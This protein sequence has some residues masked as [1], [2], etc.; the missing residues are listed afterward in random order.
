LEIPSPNRI[1]VLG[2]G[3][4]GTS[5]LRAARARIPGIA[6]S[7]WSRSPSSR[8]AVTDV[9]DAFG[10]PAEALVGADCVI[11]ATPVDN[12]PSL[13][14]EISP[15]LEG[16]AWVTD[17]GSTKRGV[18]LAA[19]KSLRDPSRFVGGHPMA[20]SEKGG[21]A[22]ARA[23]LF[24]GRP[25]IVTSDALTHP[26]VTKAADAFWSKLGGRV[27]H[28]SPEAHDAAVAEISHL[29]HAVASLLAALLAGRQPRIDLAAGGLRDTTRIAAGDPA[30]W[31]PIL[32][33]NADHVAPLLAELAADVQLLR[34]TLVA[35]NA[36]EL[37]R[38]LEAARDFRRKL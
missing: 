26:N 14:A 5:V 17:V 38:H 16:H 33:E 37:R 36:S 35:G 24:E 25:C 29:P 34:E 2:V 4:L 1:A 15:S 22:E 19:L 23:D 9:C 13:L 6:L 10:T 3:L 27:V 7:A 28:L 32:L 8:A 31:V 30:L 11:L 20:G 18:H 12:F 21:A